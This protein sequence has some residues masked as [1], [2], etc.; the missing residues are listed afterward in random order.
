MTVSTIVRAMSAGLSQVKQATVDDLP[1]GLV[2]LLLQIDIRLLKLCVWGRRGV[3]DRHPARGLVFVYD[4]VW[5]VELA[6]DPREP[7]VV[8]GV[9]HNLTKRPPFLLRQ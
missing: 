8:L 2:Q 5:M 7:S 3:G 6:A 4:C 1:L 9:G